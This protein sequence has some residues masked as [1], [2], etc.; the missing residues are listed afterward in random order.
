[1]LI[2][3][4]KATMGVVLPSGAAGGLVSS[5][6]AVRAAEAVRPFGDVFLA[7]WPEILFN[8]I[9]AG[10][11]A[12]VAIILLDSNR[13]NQLRLMATSFLLGAFWLGVWT[14]F[15]ELAANLATAI[16]L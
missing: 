6:I 4:T 14:R 12:L 5:L 16:K 3:E 13:Q 7:K 2:S 1:M 8:A 15:G 11:I 9:V 10:P